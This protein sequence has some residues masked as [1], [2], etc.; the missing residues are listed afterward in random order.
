LIEFV[1]GDGKQVLSLVNTCRADLARKAGKPSSDNIVHLKMDYVRDPKQP[2]LTLKAFARQP[3]ARG[4]AAVQNPTVE[5]QV[6]KNW[7]PKVES[8]LTVPRPL[9]YL[10]PA[11]HQDV[12]RTLL[13]HRI[14]IGVFGKD[15]PVDAE[16]YQIKEI[17]PATADYVAPAK[18]EVDLKPG[19]VTARKGDFYVSVEQPA[20]NLIPCLLEPQSEFG[21][22]RYQSYKLVP[23]KGAAFPLV[24]VV[25][26]KPT[27]APYVEAAAK[28]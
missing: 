17:E 26:S 23:Q 2:E 4:N 8:R 27:V 13:D 28:R 14:A 11:E 15:T 16:T 22:I 24:R 3:G 10:I 5:T 21:L 25:K 6:V 9:G 19:K 1:A 20:A 12:I 18:I 7:F